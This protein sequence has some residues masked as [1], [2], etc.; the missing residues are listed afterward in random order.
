MILF[1]P[2]LSDVEKKKK[3]AASDKRYHETHR[4]EIKKYY[5]KNSKKIKKRVKNGQKRILRKE[6]RFLEDIEKGTARN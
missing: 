3:R 2:L 6:R 1:I 5:K 4:E